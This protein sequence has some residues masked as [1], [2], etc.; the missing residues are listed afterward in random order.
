MKVEIYSDVV[1]PWCYLGERR[2]ARALEGFTESD[3]VEV[4]FRPF[5]LDPEMPESPIPLRRY[6]E[7]RF[8]GSAGGMQA[9]ITA[10]GAQEGI[11]FDWE[12]ALAV[13]TRTAH[14]LLRYAERHHGGGVQRRL[15]EAL[16]AA[17][18]TRGIDIS[19]HAALVELAVE[20]GM[21]A[22]RTRRYLDSGEGAAE[23]AEDLALARGLGIQAVPTF[24][25]DE[26]YL[27]EGAQPVELFAQV[28]EEVL[29]R[30]EED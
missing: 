28:L 7:G 10:I 30:E 20:A 4:V 3:E 1:C 19:D 13:N 23:L 12:R 21:D 11:R 17:H 26:H 2:F 24:V 22:R 15:A 27:V 8:G 5:Q 14:R 18:F 29:T 6:L 9:R 16:F 25:F